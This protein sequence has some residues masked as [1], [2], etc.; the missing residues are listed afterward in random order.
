MIRKLAPYLA[1][2][3]VGAALL[4]A[5]IFSLPSDPVPLGRLGALQVFSLFL[6]LWYSGF[7]VVLALPAFRYLESRQRRIS[8]Y[9]S[10]AVGGALFSIAAAIATWA[11]GERQLNEYVFFLVLATVAGATSFFVRFR[12]PGA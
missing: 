4:A 11:N 8:S 5:W 1:G 3:I 9:T 2:L 7:F 6:G 12:R 10:A